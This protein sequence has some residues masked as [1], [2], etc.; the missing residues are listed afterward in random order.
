M[1]RPKIFLIS[2]LLF[3]ISGLKANEWQAQWITASSNQNVT[4]SWM[5]FHKEFTCDQVPREAIA[6]IAA[7]S[8]YWLWIN[9]EMVVF[10]G[11]LKRGPTRQD[12][13]YDEMDI[14]SYLRQGNNSL[15][16]LLWYFGKDGFSHNSSGR[17]G[18]LF[19]SISNDFTLIS[20]KS[21]LADIHPS[22]GNT[23]PPYPN[24]RLPESNILFDARKGDFSFTRDGFNPE[25]WRPV[26]VFGRPPMAPWNKL[27]KRPIPLWKDFGLKNY[28][29][30]M[31]LPFISQG[32]TVYCKLPYNAQVTPYFEIEAPEGLTI[33]ILTDHYFGGGPSNVRAEYITREGSQNF[34]CLGWMN[35][36]TVMYLFPA[37]VKVK[38]LKYRE[39]GYDTEFAGSFSTDDP[40]LNRFWEKALRTLYVTMRDT[41][42]DCPDRERAQWWGD[43]VVESGEAFYAL[44]RKSDQITR[45]GILELINWQREDSVIYAPVP[46]G[47]FNRELPGQMLASIGYYG[48]WNYYWN[49]GDIETI[50]QV[51]EG[52]KKHLSLWQTRE[53]GSLVVRQG[54]WFWGDWGTN[55]DMSLL[56]N[57]W[58]YLALDGYKRMSELLGYTDEA[59]LIAD[60]ME[61]FKKVFNE[62]FWNGYE[63][64]SPDFTNVKTDD[65]PQALAVV[66][67]LAD[68]DK[69]EAIYKVLQRE[70]NAS[71]YMEKY[72][73]E[74]LFIMN[75]PEFAM[76][77]F[78]QRFGEMVNHP[79]ITTLWEGWG[80]GKK[81]FGGGSVNHAWSGGG[82]TVLS[83]YMVGLYPEEAAW[84]KFRVRPQMG[85]VNKVSLTI[86]SVSGEIAVEINKSKTEFILKVRVPEGTKAFVHIPEYY[87]SIKLDDQMVYRNDRQ[88]RS[89]K[90]ISRNSD[91]YYQIYE[92][93]EGN[94]IF[95]ADNINK[96]Q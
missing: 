54:D 84:K 75:R 52:V 89:Q 7:D 22:F 51:Y 46:S 95:H 77:R 45:K 21:W 29:E 18:L 37:G 83:R 47:N 15:A 10:E 86:H 8:K 67:G 61:K 72:V 36:H 80:V 69:Y 68:E 96:R 28:P 40:F 65:R 2:S 92:V 5:S 63:Y 74:A 11:Q 64:R 44:C 48:F 13:Y 9:G 94:F 85:L 70:M 38:S 53:D 87:G 26:Y 79:E 82:L 24:Y 30:A 35:G 3:L 32:D 78:K 42:M 62:R 50:R 39:T 49:T 6:R 59:N 73:M 23:G 58:Y 19:E 41:Y 31:E 90:I 60:R 93:P 14:S 33:G 57:G 43:V 91:N 56:M 76:E 55:K 27:V 17:A 34:E 16:V 12:T 1:L 25:A 81:G 20:D 71:P 4:N 88:I 66:S